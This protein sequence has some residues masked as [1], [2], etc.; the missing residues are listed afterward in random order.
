M[1]YDVHFIDKKPWKHWKAIASWLGFIRYAHVPSS[2][3]YKNPGG[4]RHWLENLVITDEDEII[5]TCLHTFSKVRWALM[6]NAVQ[7]LVSYDIVSCIGHVVRLCY[8]CSKPTPYLDCLRGN[9]L[10][11]DNPLLQAS[12]PFSCKLAKCWHCVIFRWNSI[13]QWEF[14]WLVQCLRHSIHN[15]SFGVRVPLRERWLRTAD[16]S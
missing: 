11:A 7:V 15:I 10:S 16:N 1:L 5:T 13:N 3:W 6:L 8:S 2:N 9:P 12:G 4:E 14:V